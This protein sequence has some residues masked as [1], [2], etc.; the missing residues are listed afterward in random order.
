[1]SKAEDIESKAAQWLMRRDA[2]PTEENRDFT[3]WLAAD[4]RHRAAY[5][6]LAAYAGRA[7]A[8]ANVYFGVVAP[9]EIG[10]QAAL[11]VGV[12]CGSLV[13]ALLGGELRLRWVPESGWREVFGTSRATRWALAFAGAFL[14]EVGAGIAGGCTSGLAVSGGVTLAPGAFVFMAG[15]FAAGI[16]TAL[17]VARR[18]R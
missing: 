16:P 6:R 14:I 5:L 3:A 2:A 13:S 4:P 7:I 17:L 18:R 8:P 9:P 11:L 1:M 12:F 15:M 10:W